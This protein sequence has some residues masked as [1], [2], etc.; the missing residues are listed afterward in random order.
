MPFLLLISLLLVSDFLKKKF[1]F[2]VNFFCR[3]HG[4]KIAKRTDGFFFA[5]LIYSPLLLLSRSN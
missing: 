5:C 4:T 1:F 2:F 3:F